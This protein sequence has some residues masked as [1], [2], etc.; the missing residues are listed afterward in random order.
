MHVLE[1]VVRA[2]PWRKTRL[3]NMK[4][5]LAPAR[6]IL[7]D[8]PRALV[9]SA[10][11]ELTG[12]RPAMPWIPYNVIRALSPL[13]RPTWRVLEYGAGMSTVWWA[14][15]VRHVHSI[16]LDEHWYQQ[17]HLL[18]A[19][20]K[21]DNVQLELHSKHAYTAHLDAYPDGYFDCVVVDGA[22]RD[23]VVAATLRLV[24][25]PGG[26]LYLDNTDQGAQWP[27]YAEA[28][29]LLRGDALRTHAQ[30]ITAYTGFAPAQSIANEGLLVVW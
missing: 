29:R 2:D 30:R 14:K 17:V 12:W 16:E 19:Q 22:F 6:C 9:G 27:M 28:E 25:R 5:R 20:R 10:A 4:G 23:E 13:V 8:F 1:R 11:R 7:T 15:R 21:L 26:V 3:H 18:L 24:R